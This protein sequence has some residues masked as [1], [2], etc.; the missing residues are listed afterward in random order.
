MLHYSAMLL[1][2]SE[3]KSGSE[4]VFLAWEVPIDL[5][6]AFLLPLWT[7]LVVLKATLI[8]LII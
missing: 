7:H 6:F 2:L 8:S 5:L 1:Y 4:L 3:V